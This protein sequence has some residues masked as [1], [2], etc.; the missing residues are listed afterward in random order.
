LKPNG[1]TAFAV[2]E[3][4]RK[5]SGLYFSI[6]V[7]LLIFSQNTFADT[8]THKPSV[9][10]TPANC[11][12]DK[13]AAPPFYITTI[14]GGPVDSFQQGYLRAGDKRSVSGNIYGDDENKSTDNFRI[15]RDDNPPSKRISR[16]SIVQINA[17]TEEQ[18]VTLA[19]QIRTAQASNHHFYVPVKVTETHSTYT[20]FKTR[21][22]REK[23]VKKND[24]GHLHTAV[25]KA[26]AGD[27]TFVV[28]KD[29]MVRWVNKGDKHPHLFN[30][31]G[32]AV[33]PKLSNDPIQ[34]YLGT[35]CC[36]PA[37]L[38]NQIYAATGDEK[39]RLK[40][41]CTFAYKY[42]VMA[43][44]SKFDQIDL[45]MRENFCARDGVLRAIDN[46]SY[47]NLLGVRR[48]LASE[49]GLEGMNLDGIEFNDFG[50][51]RLPMKDEETPRRDDIRG[52]AADGS[53][54]HY[55]GPDMAKSDTWGKP[56]TICS[57]MKLS[58]RF[59]AS[60][61]AGGKSAK[62]CTSRI[63]DI[64]F[65][66]PG[67]QLNNLD[68]L[69]HVGHSSGECVDVRPFRNDQ[70]H[71]GVDLLSSRTKGSYDKQLT[72]EFIQE[73]VKLGA[74]NILFHD[75]SIENASFANNHADHIHVCFKES[76]NTVKQ[77]CL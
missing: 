3:L 58:K 51:V 24:T 54:V 5:K 15:G 1:T 73:A 53:Y 46:E 63:G 10:I 75:S 23:F 62:R 13:S 36:D 52:E 41:Q 29:T 30:L 39:D 31:K 71:A 28:Q 12:E 49:F 60:C 61:M 6:S 74:S 72:S 21:A 45:T 38:W 42:L 18:R 67:K 27:H 77:A 57:I 47:N 9:D 34:K 19:N 14:K 59:K 7:L 37:S 16:G 2:V 44:E 56:T 11:Q 20:Q 66:T 40:N 48:T 65:A 4:L 33:R 35:R 25:L 22:E 8:F 43:P 68:P 64:G 32:Y 76:N 26:N 50:N 70:S 17:S 55:K 69:G